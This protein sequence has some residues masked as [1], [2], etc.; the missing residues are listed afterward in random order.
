[1]E[2][3]YSIVKCLDIFFVLTELFWI[4]PQFFITIEDIDK[5]DNRGRATL[6]VTLTEKEANN[7]STVAIGFDIYK[8]IEI[9][10]YYW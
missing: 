8:V 1:L 6:I 9:T 4:N 2:K 5:T 3:F 10:R 7:K